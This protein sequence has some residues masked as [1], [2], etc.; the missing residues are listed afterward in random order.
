MA[1]DLT[2]RLVTPPGGR[3]KRHSGGRQHKTKV[4]MNK[5]EAEIVKARSIVL[6]VSAPRVLLESAIGVPPFTKTER[7][8]LIGELLAVR[9]LL[10]N[11]TNNV[12]Q[13]ARALNMDVEVPGSQISGVLAASAKAVARVED[14]V[15]R[16]AP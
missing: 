15:D 3:N 12:N 13:I 10:A 11:M 8:A 6:G 4:L 7:Q 5:E 16:L 2:G 14:A 1:E 9:R